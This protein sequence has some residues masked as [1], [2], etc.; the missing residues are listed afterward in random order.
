MT[1]SVAT[2]W[3]DN[4]KER[5][6]LK[7]VTEETNARLA[8]MAQD[9]AFLGGAKSRCLCNSG[10]SMFGLRSQFV[11]RQATVD[12]SKCWTTVDDRLG[13]PNGGGVMLARLD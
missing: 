11:G 1:T 9:F 4:I 13:Q 5:A 8:R 3:S 12:G 10:G 6:N 2:T 7:A